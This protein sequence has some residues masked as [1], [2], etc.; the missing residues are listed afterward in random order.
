MQKSSDF[1]IKE[2]NKKIELLRIAWRKYPNRRK[3]IERQARALM[4]SKNAYRFPQEEKHERRV[5]EV[6]DNLL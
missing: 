3:I 6:I 4:Y 1:E 2:I 5:N